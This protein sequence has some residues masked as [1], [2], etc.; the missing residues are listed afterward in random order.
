M[1]GIARPVAG[2]QDGSLASRTKILK[3]YLQGLKALGSNLLIRFLIRKNSG[4]VTAAPQPPEPWKQLGPAH[5]IV[6]F[7]ENA[8]QSMRNLGYARA[9]KD[10]AAQARCRLAHEIEIT[11]R[12]KGAASTQ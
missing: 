10:L 11:G 3:N 1:A 7:F 2:K 6:P 5:G 9:G 4:F 12:H 8:G